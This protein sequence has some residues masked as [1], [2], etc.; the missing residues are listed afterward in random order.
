VSI[1]NSQGKKERMPK[2]GW[3]KAIAD[4]KDRIKRLEQTITVYRKR[5][6]EGDPWPGREEAAV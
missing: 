6:K 5:K 2:S 1:T 4:A 3:D